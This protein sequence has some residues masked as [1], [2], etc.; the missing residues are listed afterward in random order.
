MIMKL[1]LMKNKW[2]RKSAE[3]R[4]KKLTWS[5]II[6]QHQSNK[7]T[8]F[9]LVRFRDTTSPQQHCVVLQDVLR[10]SRPLVA[11]GEG[12][13]FGDKIKLIKPLSII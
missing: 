7:W 5:F 10:L 12:T 6:L 1:N 8:H 3:D 13:G 2:N 11:R 4:G 9:I